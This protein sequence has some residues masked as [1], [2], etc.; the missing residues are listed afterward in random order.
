MQVGPRHEIKNFGPSWCAL[1]DR[2]SS[3]AAAYSCAAASS[4]AAAAR[5]IV[6]ACAGLMA[7]LSQLLQTRCCLIRWAVILMALWLH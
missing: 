2:F 4:C 7:A 3:C 1:T 6:Y 5:L